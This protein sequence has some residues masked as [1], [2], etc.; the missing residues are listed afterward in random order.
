MNTS[1]IVSHEMGHCLGLFHTHH[2]TIDEGTAGECPELV[3]GSNSSICGD[4]VMDTPADPF[5]GF[6]VNLVCEWL[7]A[8]IDANGQ[9][10]DPDENIIMSY[11]SPVCMQYFTDGQTQRMLL[12]IS[13]SSVLQQ[14]SSANYCCFLSDLVINHPLT[15]TQDFR[16][17]NL[18]TASSAINNNIVV[19]FRA[20]Q[21]ILKPGFTVSGN[22]SGEFRAYID[23]CVNNSAAMS[24]NTIED[25]T[26]LDDTEN[27]EEGSS[28]IVY[29]NPSNGV[30][31]IGI[32]NVQNGLIL[33]TNLYG[34]TVFEKE[35]KNQSDFEINMENQ[36]TG[37]YILKVLFENIVYTSQL[38]KN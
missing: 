25:N 23:P 7:G 34:S 3:N 22:T 31:K 5:L 29:P 37:I 28:I 6:N 35:F 30:F 21:I 4:F 18:I 15:A 20:N 16:V 13:N 17:S 24:S 11:T 26:V 33:I 2:G 36:P 8:G 38:I 10:Y 9:A 1:H 12:S 32:K 14:V 19:N 27:K